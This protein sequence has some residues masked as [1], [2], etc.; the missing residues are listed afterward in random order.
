MELALVVLVAIVAL[1]V[2]AV[3]NHLADR[4]P[5]RQRIDIPPECRY[6][7]TLWPV[8]GWI[9]TWAYLVGRAR[10][11]AC[12]AAIPV[13]KPLVEIVNM[14][15]W[16]SLYQSRGPSLHFALGAFYVCIFLLVLITDLEHRLILN[17]IILPAVIVALLGA[18]LPDPPTP[19]SAIIGGAFGFLFF[20]FVAWIGR[21]AMGA[22]DVKLA[23]FIGLVVGFPNV[24][25]AL[26]FGIVAGGVTALILVLLRIKTL[27]SYIPYGPFLVFGGVLLAFFG[28]LVKQ[29]FM[30]GA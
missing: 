16:V 3:L 26:L 8:S 28:P 2:G 27:K 9:A 29:L 15:G 30:A 4:L 1:M 5:M 14:L 10:C 17:V 20:W 24:V 7:Q 13:R 25:I 18:F 19:E 11:A 22:G 6:C 23:A 12:G 21:G